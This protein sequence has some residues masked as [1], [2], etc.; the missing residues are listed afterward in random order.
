MAELCY[1]YKLSTDERQ[2][3]SQLISSF[4]KDL[5]NTENTDKKSEADDPIVARM[6]N[7][8]NNISDKMQEAFDAGHKEGLKVIPK[9]V[10][11]E[12]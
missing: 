4:H 1:I 12:K 5:E 11:F 10:G 6:N 7:I 2:E 3:L 8:L 9:F